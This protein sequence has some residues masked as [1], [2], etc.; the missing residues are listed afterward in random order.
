MKNRLLLSILLLSVL[1]VFFAIALPKNISINEVL[2]VILISVILLPIY[3]K[4]FKKQQNSKTNI[5][6]GFIY[7]LAMWV[8][9]IVGNAS[10][11]IVKFVYPLFESNISFTNWYWTLGMILFAE[12]YLQFNIGKSNR[13][14]KNIYPISSRFLG[15]VFFI[16]ILGTILLFLEIGY[17]P[18]LKGT[19]IFQIESGL[20]IAVRFWVFN[21]FSAILF[22]INFLKSKNIMY[23]GLYFFT[24]FSS[25][26]LNQRMMFFAT[27]VGSFIVF[28]VMTKNKKKLVI[29]SFL[30]G[31]LYMLINVAFLG[32][33]GD[34]INYRSKI[35]T[36]ADLSSFQSRGL[37][38]TFNEYRQLHVLI[39]SDFDNFQYG[40]TLLSVPVGFIPAPLLR[41]FGVV[42]HEIQ[43]NNSAVIY[44]DYLRSKISAGVR[45]GILGEGYINFGLFGVLI[46][47]VLGIGIKIMQ[48]NI[49]YLS[50]YDFRFAVH[51]LIFVFLLY[52][53]IGQIDA[54]GSKV[55]QFI[56]FG[57]IMKRIWGVIKL[58]SIQLKRGIKIDRI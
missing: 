58:P 30:G 36:D 3:I 22:A 38:S 44:A 11:Q 1:Y 21:S 24:L 41:A 20:S 50:I 55:G 37:V 28:W 25:A 18:I 53:L 17:I 40:L 56:I 51:I 54:I 48:K 35:T 7:F 42:K 6:F 10:Y 29:Y 15:F 16:S 45:T 4:R 33:R 13:K 52:A 32:Q 39:N 19:R 2:Q 43:L 9:F 49:D 23:L 46:M 57:F 5:S 31:I 26:F 34:Y 27:L 47:V 12:S 14:S 8:I